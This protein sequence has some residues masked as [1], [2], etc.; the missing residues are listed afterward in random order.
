VKGS[1]SLLQPDGVY[2]YG[3]IQNIL[4]QLETHLGN[5]KHIGAIE[6]QLGHLKHIGFFNGKTFPFKFV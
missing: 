4:G 1:Y 3:A 5:V 6:T 2:R